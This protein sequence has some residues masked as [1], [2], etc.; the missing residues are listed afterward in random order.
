MRLKQLDPGMKAHEAGRRTALAWAEIDKT[1][2]DEAGRRKM[3]KRRLQD[4]IGKKMRRKRRHLNERAGQ[5]M[6]RM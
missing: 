4:V 3:K 2:Q 5:E 1:A 6:V